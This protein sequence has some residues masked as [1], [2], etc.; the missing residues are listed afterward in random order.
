VKIE[1]MGQ[2][3]YD[4]EPIAKVGQAYFGD[5]NAIDGDETFSGLDKTE[6]RQCKRRF[7]GA[8]IGMNGIIVLAYELIY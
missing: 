5:I 2:T 4:G 1:V 8:C 7:S 3:G 6:E